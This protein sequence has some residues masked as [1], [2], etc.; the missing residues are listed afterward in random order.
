MTRTHD[1][2]KATFEAHAQ[3]LAK[4][5]T[6]T[7]LQSELRYQKSEGIH[8]YCQ[9]E[10]GVDFGRGGWQCPACVERAIEIKETTNDSTK[11]IEHIKVIEGAGCTPFPEYVDLRDNT[12]QERDQFGNLIESVTCLPACN[13]A[14]IAWLETV[15]THYASLGWR[16]NHRPRVTKGFVDWSL[17]IPNSD[18][19]NGFEETTLAACL[20]LIEAVADRLGEG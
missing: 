20:A 11:T 10:C 16:M 19:V 1:E 18:R 2:I 5:H 9:C 17:D 6:I 7:Q 14:I 3:V 15:R 4:V 12:I 8:T 13:D